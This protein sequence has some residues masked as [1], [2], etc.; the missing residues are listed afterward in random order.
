MLPPWINKLVKLSRRG[1][2]RQGRR[3]FRPVLELLEAR[4][5]P[6][7][8]VQFINRTTPVG[9]ITNATSVNYTVVFT[10]SVSGVDPTDFKVTTS[11]SVKAALPVAVSGS[12]S[13]YNVAVNGIHGSG[14]LRLDLIDDDSIQALDGPLGGPGTGNG[15]FQGQTYN[16]LQAFPSVVSINRATP[17]GPISNASTVSFTVT[18]S[19]AVTGV[20]PT[21]FKLATTGTVGSNLTQV[22]PVSSTVY[23]VTVSGI[24]GNGTVGLNLVDDGSIRDAAGNP[25]TLN[26]APASFQN[27]AI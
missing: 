18:F 1:A 8:F 7:P 24:T 15:S 17:G 6:A 2:K 25:L 14:D 12:G 26:N 16:I 3:L 19:E 20:D 22:T 23:T 13:S 10:E 27:Q 21:D 11:N 5:E 4:I 9:P